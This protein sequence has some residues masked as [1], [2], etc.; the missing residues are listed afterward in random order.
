MWY[1]GSKPAKHSLGLFKSVRYFSAFCVIILVS[2][3]CTFH[4]AQMLLESFQ[5]FLNLTKV[6]LYE[7]HVS[8]RIS[9]GNPGKGIGF[10]MLLM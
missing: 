4:V 10:Q 6:Y 5:L 9:E 2:I 8:L 3:F 1:D 7:L